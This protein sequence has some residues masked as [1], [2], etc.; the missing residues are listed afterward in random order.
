MTVA[1]CFGGGGGGEEVDNVLDNCHPSPSITL[2][3]NGALCFYITVAD[4]RL[5]YQ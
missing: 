4:W 1:F 5:D 2:L 3:F